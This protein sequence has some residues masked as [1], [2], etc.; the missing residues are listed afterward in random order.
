METSPLA[1]TLF[2]AGSRVVAR[3]T[4]GHGMTIDL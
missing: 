3:L 4:A 1:K 2:V